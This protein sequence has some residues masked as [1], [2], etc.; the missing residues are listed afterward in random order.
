MLK[1][2]FDFTI[3]TNENQLLMQVG[4]EF[5]SWFAQ[6]KIGFCSSPP[7][8]L[9][10]GWETLQS[11]VKLQTVVTSSKLNRLGLGSVFPGQNWVACWSCSVFSRGTEH[12]VCNLAHW[13]RFAFHMGLTLDWPPMSEPL[14]ECVC[15][16]NPLF[17]CALCFIAC[18]IH[19]LP[20]SCPVCTQDAT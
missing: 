13:L 17:T 19:T 20:F 11:N 5:W 3:E 10:G 15:A 8:V 2:K 9:Q 4:I 18:L 6:T 7:R 1:L 16:T 12:L 14:C